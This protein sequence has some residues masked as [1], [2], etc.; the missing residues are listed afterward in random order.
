MHIALQD[1][2]AD[3][4]YETVVET[5]GIRGEERAR[6]EE[7]ALILLD[8]MLPGRDGFQVCRNL[9]D[10]SIHTPILMLTARNTTID[11]VM[12]L[13]IGA[14]DYLVKPFDMQVLVA[15]V[16]ALIRRSRLATRPRAAA[17]G[18]YRFGRFILDTSSREL[19][20]DGR[21]VDLSLQEYRLLEFFV[22]NP[23]RTVDRNELLNEVWGY[24]TETSTR[25]ID[26]HVSW[27]RR[28]IDEP[29]N[30][31][32]LLTVRGYGYRFVVE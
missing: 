13:R 6:S 21:R 5:D 14:D 11:T 30:P 10:V 17:G 22:K 25:T 31:R 28:K 24:E 15:R 1:R 18:L 16:D 12:G 19:R 29:R 7:F 26:V 32:Y 8:V 3:E 23:G 9:R 27:L 4:G 20:R 2:L